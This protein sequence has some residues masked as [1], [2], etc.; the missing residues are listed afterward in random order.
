MKIWLTSFT[1]EDKEYAGPRIFA[2][3]ERKAQ[4]LCDIQGLILEGPLEAIHE[5]ELYLTLL[6]KDENTVLH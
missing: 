2:E 1:Y 3:T 6:E 4:F 5:H